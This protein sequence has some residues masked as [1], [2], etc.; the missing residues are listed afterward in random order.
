METFLND[1]WMLSFHDPNDDNWTHASYV[2][3]HTISTAEDLAQVQKAY[4][5][6]WEHGMFFL[7][8]EHIAPMWEDSHNVDGGCFS[9]KVMRPEVPER[10]YRLCAAI[11]GETLVRD[12]EDQREGGRHIGGPDTAREAIWDM[13]NGISI[14]PKR[15]YCIVRIWIRK[16]DFGRQGLYD[17]H[18]PIYTE[19]LFKPHVQQRDFVHAPEGEGARAGAIEAAA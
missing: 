10:W 15:N 11:L 5:P 7:M 3:L 17:L 9:F 18:V 16:G 6:L 19:I 14:S 8:R 12:V 1:V 13:V 2:N 4:A